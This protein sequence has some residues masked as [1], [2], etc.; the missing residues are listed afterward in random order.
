[1]DGFHD[2]ASAAW[3]CITR[4]VPYDESAEPL[5]V[6]IRAFFCDGLHRVIRIEH[7]SNGVVRVCRMRH[8]VP[9]LCRPMLTAPIKAANSCAGALALVLTAAALAASAARRRSSAGFQGWCRPSSSLVLQGGAIQ[10]IVWPL[11]ID[12]KSMIAGCQYVSWFSS[13]D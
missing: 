7:A 1:M 13:S 3:W 11:G 5:G 8:R 2:A 9:M 12:T 6:H 4:R 10:L